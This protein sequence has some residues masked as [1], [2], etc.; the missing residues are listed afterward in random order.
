MDRIGVVGASYRTVHVDQ[1][2]AASL[3]ADFPRENLVELARLAGV[4][5][6]GY[7]GTCNRV[8]FYFRG[9]TRIHTN[10]LLFHLR[11]SL[12]DLTNGVRYASQQN[13]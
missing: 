8:E 12:A 4:S 5:E 7:L 13:L 6:L 1:L 10:P 9:D 11:R 3:P 2:A